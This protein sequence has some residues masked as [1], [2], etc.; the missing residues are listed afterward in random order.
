VSNTDS[1][2][3]QPIAKSLYSLSCL[4]SRIYSMFVILCRFEKLSRSRNFALFS[5][6]VKVHCRAHKSLLLS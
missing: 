6:I 5:G 4:G 2:V 1:S 3:V